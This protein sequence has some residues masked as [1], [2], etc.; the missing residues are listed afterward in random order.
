MPRIS[1]NSHERD[2]HYGFDGHV[3]A[4]PANDTISF[5]AGTS[6][7]NTG[8]LDDQGSVVLGRSEA[9]TLANY[10]GGGTGIIQT[11]GNQS[12]PSSYDIPVNIADPTEVYTLIN[13]AYGE[14][15]DTVGSVEFV[16]HRRARLHGQPG[17]RAEYPR[18]E[19]RRLQRHDRPR[20]TGATPI[21]APRRTEGARV[22][23]TSRDS[24]CRPR[25]SRPL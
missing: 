21:S 7:I 9:F 16:G 13:S 15:G 20:G 18:S 22:A 24:S 17:G 25:S 10:P 14:Y 11:R 6:T 19:Q 4:W 5:P 1:V 2:A 3:D 23:S 12:S 8:T